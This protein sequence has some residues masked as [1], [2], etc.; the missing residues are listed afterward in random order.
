M[1]LKWTIHEL[2]KKAKNDNIIEGK[3]DLRPYMKPDLIDFVDIL[4]TFIMGDFHYNENEELFVF[5]IQIKTTIIMLCAISL[6]EIP[7]EVSFSSELN[8][9]KKYFDDNTHLI[10][11]I[12]IDLKPY[13]F[14][15]ILIE[16]PMRI[17]SSKAYEEY[18]ESLEKLSDVELM[19]NSP[20]A[21]LKK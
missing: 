13:I 16:K 4:D 6:E 8:F 11:G 5:N 14:S 17:I 12:T 21:K 15:E 1:K 19:E 9:S 18:H 3:L 2:I 20:F 7:V 10:D